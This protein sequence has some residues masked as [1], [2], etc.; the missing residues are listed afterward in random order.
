VPAAA[1]NT[2]FGFGDLRA[3]ILRHDEAAIGAREV[4]LRPFELKA[5][6]RVADRAGYE[7]FLLDL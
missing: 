4:A 5:V 3:G 1:E 7:Y 2:C 6:S